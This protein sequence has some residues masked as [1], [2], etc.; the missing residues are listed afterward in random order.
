MQPFDG[1]GPELVN[2][3]AITPETGRKR[4]AAL[5]NPL[6]LSGVGCQAGIETPDPGSASRDCISQ[7]VMGND[8]G[9]QVTTF[10]NPFFAN[11][12]L[13]PIRALEN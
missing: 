13:R 11:D 7:E 4:A 6:I 1:L 10:M 5:A 12:I 2:C 8:M 3:P 9:H